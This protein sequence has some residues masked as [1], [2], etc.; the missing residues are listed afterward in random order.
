[1]AVTAIKKKSTTGSNGYPAQYSQPS[2]KGKK[3]W[4]KHV[5]IEEVETGLEEVRAEER[6]T[7]YVFTS[8]L[9]VII[10][11]TYQL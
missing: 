4:R 1:M 11:L 2:R 6:E 7:G 3:A 10:K 8:S 9:D 5:D